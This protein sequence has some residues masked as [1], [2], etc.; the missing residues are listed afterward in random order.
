MKETGE[1]F[2]FGNIDRLWGNNPFEMYF[3]L[4]AVL[5]AEEYC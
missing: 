2:A 5:S 1:S 3:K 4:Q